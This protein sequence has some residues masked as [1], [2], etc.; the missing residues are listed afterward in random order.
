MLVTKETNA[1]NW[2]P[3]FSSDTDQYY[4]NVDNI[5]K[6]SSGQVNAWFK[7]E[8]VRDTVKDGLTIGDYTLVLYQID[9]EQ[10]KFGVISSQTYKNNQPLSNGR[11]EQSFVKMSPAIPETIGEG[12]VEKAC[13]A[14]EILHDQ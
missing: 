2:F 7:R 6:N 5:K 13:K 8:I 1:A 4:L 11:F 9:C 3:V 14:W 10:N 12:A